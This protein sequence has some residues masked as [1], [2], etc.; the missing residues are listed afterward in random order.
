MATGDDLSGASHA[1][2]ALLLDQS[3]VCGW[4]PSQLD[5]EV[6]LLLPKPGPALPNL[7]RW[8]Q[9]VGSFSQAELE[10]LK[11]ANITLAQLLADK[12]VIQEN[13]LSPQEKKALIQRNL[14]VS[15][16]ADQFVNF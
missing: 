2:D 4:T 14:Q 5:R 13:K 15:K 6:H 11:P 16:L 10:K 3:Y 1:L 7:Q 12:M 8:H 9:H